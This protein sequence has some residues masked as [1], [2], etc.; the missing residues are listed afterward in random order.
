MNGQNEVPENGAEQGAGQDAAA[1]APLPP[2]AN[3]E[4]KAALLLSAML[5]LMAATVAYLMYAR[6]AFESVQKLVLMANDAEGVM[7]G[8]DV[9]FS[10]FPIGRVS[11]IE[12]SQDGKARMIVDVAKKDAHWLRT[13]SVF[14]MERALVGGTRLRAFSGILSD[15][16]LPE[17]AVREVLVGDAAA[18]I[19]ALVA[20][21]K[22][23]LQNL[24]TLTANDS[25]LEASLRNVRAATERL[26]GKSGALG[27]LAGS[28]ENAQKM[29]VM[30]DRANRLLASVDQ[31]ARK[32]DSQVFG[33]QGALPEAQAAIA[34]LN[35]LLADTRASLKKVDGLLAD[36]QVVGAN[37][38]GASADLGPLRAE[39]ESNLRKVEQLVNEINRKWPFKREAEVK[40]P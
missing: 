32:A 40:L 4:F 3:V 39:V 19:P 36:A 35:G 6:G 9:T 12:L 10:G 15:P 7:V 25:S 27:V 28:D 24:N 22:D 37:L 17:G 38:K 18:E 16:P 11:Q 23:L 33:K 8:M 1:L 13:S 34:Q 2:I 31:L 29:F 20:A 5:L 14:T 21:A 30:I 26:A